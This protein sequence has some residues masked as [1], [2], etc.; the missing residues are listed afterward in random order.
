MLTV[1]QMSR[2]NLN[3]G[4]TVSKVVFLAVFQNPCS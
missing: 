2:K 1:V 3:E 4:K